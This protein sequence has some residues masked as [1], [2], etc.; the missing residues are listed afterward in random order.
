M[1]RPT[2]FYQN[3]RGSVEDM[4]KTLGVFFFDSQCMQCVSGFI[5]IDAVDCQKVR[6]SEK[7]HGIAVK[8][9]TVIQGHPFCCYGDDVKIENRRICLYACQI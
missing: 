7:L 3:R 8:V 9:I 2:K 4:T 5:C 6:F 1:C